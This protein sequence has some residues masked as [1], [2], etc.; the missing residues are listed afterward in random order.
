[1]KI[2]VIR[3]DT[4]VLKIQRK[5]KDGEVITTKPDK[6]FFTVKKNYH[7]KDYLFQ[8]RLDEDIIYD[9]DEN[10]Y[11]ITI[12]PSDTDDKSY[13]SY[14]FDIEIITDN[15]VKTIAIGTFNILKEVTFAENEV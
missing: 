7:I 14:V 5:N 3:G 1:M 6:M 2:D 15:I 10:F 11:Y 12:N 4:K 13:G 9:E 8:K